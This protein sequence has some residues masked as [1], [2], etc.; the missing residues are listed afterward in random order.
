MSCAVSIHI[1]VNVPGCDHRHQHLSGSETAAWQMAE[2]ANVAG[3]RSLQVLRGGHATRAAV[4]GALTGAAGVLAGGDQL[5]ISYSG[6]GGR[7]PDRERDERSGLDQ[8]WCLADG[9]LL[10]DKLAGYWRL[11]DPG[12]R[13]LIVSDSC[14]GGGVVRDDD[15][16]ASGAA[17]AASAPVYRG[18]PDDGPR[19]DD[20]R[21]AG[22]RPMSR[23]PFARDGGH[24][25]GARGGGDRDGGFR[26]GLARD[27]GFRDGGFRDGGFRD[28][29][30]GGGA[31]DGGLR[32]DGF[33]NG[34]SVAAAE[35]ADACTLK[36]PEHDDGIRASVLLLAAADEKQEARHG[37]FSD[38]LMAVWNGGRFRGSYWELHQQ[39][40]RRVTHD[41]ARQEP[42][43]L[44][45][46]VP[47]LDFPRE[48]AFHLPREEAGRG[49]GYRDGGGCRDGGGYRG[50]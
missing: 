47:D 41:N 8:G 16:E 46:G 5:F 24:R 30:R 7:E 40:F 32:A 12:V 33:R 10:D 49:G 29:A 4:H 28:G 20:Y 34:V 36:A 17:P 38:H 31:R 1:G 35:Y 37:L 43:I 19:H 22:F 42:Q 25:D 26:D 3:Y 50:G 14:Y 2:L 39:V 23:D 45:F 21:D 6:H 9:L 18:D 44:M 15:E 27:G 13:I 11:F 48:T